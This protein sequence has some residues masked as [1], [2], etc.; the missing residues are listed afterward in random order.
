MST[1][2]HHVQICAQQKE[3]QNM[4][5]ARSFSQHQ[6]IKYFVHIVIAIPLNL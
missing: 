4:L 6:L 1:A 3:K 2:S 5:N